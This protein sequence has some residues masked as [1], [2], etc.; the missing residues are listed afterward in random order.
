MA[1]TVHLVAIALVAL[2]C[3]CA[4]RVNVRFDERQDF[5]LYRT[6][7]W[8]PNASTVV[9]QAGGEEKLHAV[10]AREAHAALRTR[11]LVYARD[12]ADL[13]FAYS[14]ELEPKAVT[15][16]ETGA[17]QLLASHH[18]SPSYEVQATTQRVDVYHEAT[19]RF[20]VTDPERPEPIVWQGALRTRIK[21]DVIRNLPNALRQL[22]DA[23][24]STSWSAGTKP[25]S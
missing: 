17:V 2:A 1:R 8:C 20:I 9:A 12:G 16:N 5:S 24:P 25:S 13:L 19:V 11:G 4:A 6:W 18:A 3:G 23:F 10:V 7:A 15:V 22:L 14:L 21:G